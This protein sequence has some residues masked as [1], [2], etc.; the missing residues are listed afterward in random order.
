[1]FL[2]IGYSSYSWLMVYF[3]TGDLFVKCAHFE[4]DLG[5]RYFDLNISEWIT[6]NFKDKY[7]GKL[8]GNSIDKPKTI[9]KLLSAADKSKKTLIPEGVKK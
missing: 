2:N 6:E 5:G 4:Q 8:S 7:K 1:M 9:I 3:E